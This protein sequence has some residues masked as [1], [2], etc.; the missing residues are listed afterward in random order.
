MRFKLHSQVLEIVSASPI[1]TRVGEGDVGVELRVVGALLGAGVG[2]LE[3]DR[4]FVGEVGLADGEIEV[5][6]RPLA[7]W[8]GVGPCVVAGEGCMADVSDDG[9]VVVGAHIPIT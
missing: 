6:C 8:V 3:Q 4:W 9:R 1:A 5:P 2:L 7:D